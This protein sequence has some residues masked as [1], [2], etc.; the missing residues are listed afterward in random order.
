MMA[1]VAR[2]REEPLPKIWA[3]TEILILKKTFCRDTKICRDL[4]TFWETLGKKQ[5]FFIYNKT[6]LG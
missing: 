4:R 5:F 1:E 6:K 3:R 2:S